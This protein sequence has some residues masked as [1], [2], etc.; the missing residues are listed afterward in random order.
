[1]TLDALPLEALRGTGAQ[2]QAATFPYRRSHDQDAATPARH[3]FVIVGAG[4]VGLTLAIDLA[5]RGISVVLLH[6]GY[7][8]T[9]MVGGSGDVS[10][11]QA[12]KQ[13]IERIDALTPERSG[14]FQH[15]N[16]ATLPW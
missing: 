1:M 6:P 15:A 13:L 2:V 12:A 8:A 5:P 16:G 10:P 9:D 3:P 14:T 7:V 11:E 4:P